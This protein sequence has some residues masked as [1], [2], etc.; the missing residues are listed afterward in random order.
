MS[1]DGSTW[2]DASAYTPDPEADTTAVIDG[3]YDHLARSLDLSS[4]EIAAMRARQ[5]QLQ[6]S[7]AHLVVDEPAR[8][9]VRMTLALVAAYEQLRPDL[10]DETVL[11]AL[12]RAFVEPLAD[13]VK[14]A[15]TALLDSAPD[16]FRA[17]VELARTRETEAFG[18][19]FEFEH[20]ADDDERFFADVRRCHYHDTLVAN[21]VPQ[22]TPVMCAFDGNWI[23]AIDPQRHGF[24]FE[25]LTTIG[26]GGTH[27][28]FHFLRQP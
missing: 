28:P 19:G 7:N 24:R 21:G 20:P 22:L 23:E 27:C 14:Q 12:R 2:D 18:A 1:T 16:P 8:H 13:V 4:G 26:L 15:T 25:R 5:E 9:N 6:T 10:D 3:F 11:A 17:M